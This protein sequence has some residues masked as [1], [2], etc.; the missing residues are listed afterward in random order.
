MSAVR[1]RCV[2]S[3]GTICTSKD[4][5]SFSATAAKFIQHE[6][7]AARSEA[8][9]REKR[10]Q[11]VQE[12]MNENVT[13]AAHQSQQRCFKKAA[14]VIALLLVSMAFCT[15]LAFTK[16][17]LPASAL[18]LSATLLWCGACTAI[19]CGRRSWRA[20][21]ANAEAIRAERVELRN[22]EAREDLGYIFDYYGQDIIMEI[23]V[24]G[25]GLT[26]SVA[27]TVAYRIS[28]QGHGWPT[29]FIWLFP[30]VAPCSCCFGLVAVTMSFVA[31]DLGLGPAVL[32]DWA[33]FYS[34]YIGPG[35]NPCMPSLAQT[36]TRSCLRET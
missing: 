24:F 1:G 22:F 33:T 36:S 25:I 11:N 29:V 23:G 15:V 16:H 26:C 19:G 18:G 3:G 8:E 34:P 10:Q 30:V 35:G 5:G 28:S 4:F 31:S 17:Q 21:F 6:E 12:A 20:N 2:S 14:T 9:L 32:T 7:T 27:M 13:C